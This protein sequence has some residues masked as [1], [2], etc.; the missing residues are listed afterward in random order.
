MILRPEHGYALLGR[1]TA[2]GE[3]S[4][5]GIHRKPSMPSF[6]SGLAQPCNG[7]AGQCQSSRS[8]LSR[9]SSCADC[10]CRVIDAASHCALDAPPLPVEVERDIPMSTRD[11]VTLRADVWRPARPG[12]FPVL[13][14]R[15]PYDKRQAST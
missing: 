5:S 13:L 2:A 3:S 9:V 11:G 12:R 4:A 15:T 10:C 6:E 7:L 14:V 1:R 8:G